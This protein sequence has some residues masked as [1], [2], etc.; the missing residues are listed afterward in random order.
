[1]EPNGEQFLWVGEVWGDLGR[2]GRRGEDHKLNCWG[3]KI[4]EYVG[5]W[6]TGERRVW[7]HV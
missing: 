5:G 4:G 7:M 6:E 3:D 1:M 2:I